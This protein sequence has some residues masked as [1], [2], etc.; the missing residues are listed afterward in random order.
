MNTENILNKISELLQEQRTKE[1]IDKM[2]NR[3]ASEKEIT[4]WLTY[5]AIGLL[6][7]M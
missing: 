1:I 6:C 2:E 7:Q 5:S 3:G 4:T